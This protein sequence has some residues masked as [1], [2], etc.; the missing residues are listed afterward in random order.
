MT[1]PPTSARSTSET[2]DGLVALVTG[3]GQRVG[4][5]IALE[6]ARSG[7]D[8]CVHYHRSEAEAR[9]VAEA[10]IALG[11]RSAVVH[12]DLCDPESWGHVVDATTS[13]LGGLDVLVNNASEFTAPTQ[14]ALSSFDPA[15]WDR[16]MRT[17]L[18]APVGLCHHAQSWLRRSGRGSVVNLCDI[19][20]DRP[21]TEHLAYCASKGGL[22][23]LTKS[24]ARS[25]APDVRVNGVSPGIAVFPE[26]YG[27]AVRER[28][29]ARVPLARAGTPEEVG[30]LV[31]FL[32]VSA[33]Y[34]T[35]QVIA[36]DG[37]R[38]ACP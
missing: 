13:R 12:G 20:A 2:A 24:L 37:G 9:A 14:D 8:V 34:V 33:P 35:G 28:L 6:L 16:V 38:S 7:C 5:A 29:V 27:D 32:V 1:M 10:V 11:R 22:V 17:N 23:N 19:A 4:R 30:A 18:V 36:I 15:L 26:D 3:G 31:R 25:L 21:W